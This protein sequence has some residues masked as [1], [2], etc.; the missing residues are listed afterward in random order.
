MSSAIP[1]AFGAVFAAGGFII[2]VSAFK[3]LGRARAVLSWPSVEGKLVSASV[4]TRS[5]HMSAGSTSSGRSYEAVAS[6]SYA[7]GGKS[8]K[9]QRIGLG[10]YRSTGKRKVQA[11]VEELA[12]APRLSVRYRPDKPEESVLEAKAYGFGLALLLGLFCLGVG[13][14]AIFLGPAFLAFFT[15]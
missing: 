8:Y 10:E 13:A 1:Y 6:Y 15:S 2:L 4:K 3:S 7:V 14:L 11:K 12:A 5:G 9:G